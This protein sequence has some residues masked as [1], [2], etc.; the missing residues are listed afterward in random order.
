M[1]RRGRCLHR[2]LDLAPAQTL[3]ADENHR[4]PRRRYVRR[5]DTPGDPERYL[6]GKVPHPSVCACGASTSPCRG[7]F[8]G[9][10]PP[11]RLP[12]KG[13]CRRS[14]LRGALPLCAGS[15]LQNPA[16]P[17]P[18]RRRGRC[19][20]R[21]LDLAP[22]Q[23]LRADENHRPPGAGACGGLTPP[24]TRKDI[25]GA[26]RRTP[27]SAPAAHPPPL[28]GEALWAAAAPKAPL[29][30]ELAAKPTEG[31]IA[32]LPRRY[33]SQARQS[34]APSCAGGGAPQPS[35]ACHAR[36]FW[37]RRT[38]AHAPVP[39]RRKKKRHAP[40]RAWQGRGR[41]ENTAA[42][43]Q[44]VPQGGRRYSA[45]PPFFRLRRSALSRK[46]S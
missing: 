7:G 43:G 46:S 19:L 8:T 14:R 9:R 4:P 30:G 12:C 2:P 25:C 13:S 37:P 11:Q 27:P 40:G 45:M 32:G 33:P 23:T 6:R 41:L 18:K 20:H 3:R 42:A 21:P 10:Q 34:P 15:V 28:A 24:A 36:R 16:E 31:C 26:R 35:S 1:L 17:C 39:G 5:S 38:K 29:Q 44:G 22:A